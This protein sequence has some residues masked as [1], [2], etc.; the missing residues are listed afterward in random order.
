MTA[1]RVGVASTAMCVKQTMLVVLWFL[2]E[3]EQSVIRT[4]S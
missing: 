2:A 3:K 1:T 4:A